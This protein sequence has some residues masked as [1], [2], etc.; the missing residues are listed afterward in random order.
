[1]SFDENKIMWSM[2]EI[3]AGAAADR[4]Y[5]AIRDYRKQGNTS[6]SGLILVLTKKA[7]DLYAVYEYC[8]R[9]DHGLKGVLDRVKDLACMLERDNDWIAGR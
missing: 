4:V 9:G 7:G 1:M 8:F 2:V 3:R 5:E 6:T